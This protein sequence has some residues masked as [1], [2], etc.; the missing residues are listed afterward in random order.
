MSRENFTIE[1]SSLTETPPP[2]YSSNDEAESSDGSEIDFN[3]L[4]FPLR[5]NQ[6]GAPYGATEWSAIG[7][8]S[9]PAAFV[10]SS[11][12]SAPMRTFH[13][14]PARVATQ[15]VPLQ[16]LQDPRVASYHEFLPQLDNPPTDS[17]NS[18]DDIQ[19]KDPF[20]DPEDSAPRYQG[21]TVSSSSWL[22]KKWTENK[23]IFVILL[24]NTP[25]FAMFVMDIVGTYIIPK[26]AFYRNVVYSISF[27]ITYTCL[28]LLTAAL[29]IMWFFTDHFH[30]AERRAAVK[31][32]F[33]ERSGKGKLFMTV[34][35][36]LL[37]FVAIGGV[38]FWPM[39]EVIWL[40]KDISP[41]Y[42]SCEERGLKSSI[43]LQV[44]SGESSWHGEPWMSNNATIRSG[45]ESF[46]LSLSPTIRPGRNYDQFYL[47][48]ARKLTTPDLFFRVKGDEMMIYLKEKTYKFQYTVPGVPGVYLIKNGTFSDDRDF[49]LSFP[50]VD[51]P[52]HS[53]TKANWTYTHSRPWVELVDGERTVLKTVE[54]QA[55]DKRDTMLRM[56]A[57]YSV[58]EIVE[59]MKKMEGILIGLGRLMVELAKWGLDH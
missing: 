18:P 23:D 36:A 57:A 17:V 40:Q 39:I 8:G 52:L 24:V 27:R 9:E 51:P 54:N 47:A 33:I 46:G 13:P 35:Y 28:G 49:Y 43:L 11:F 41:A 2:I 5:L 10:A 58:N 38:A 16:H 7:M 50:T 20:A 29:N 25:F 14:S 4:H 15:T 42:P 53:T 6:F 34:K 22:T 55:G 56:C 19:L 59:D 32:R 45:D 44:A 31:R 37:F 21:S 26:S 48:P 12:S 3:E 30:N 1:N